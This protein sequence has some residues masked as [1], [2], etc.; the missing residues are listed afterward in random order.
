MPMHSNFSRWPR[1]A[2]IAGGVALAVIA[3]LATATLLLDDAFVR[4]FISKQ[5][6][7]RTGRTFEVRGPFAIDWSLRPQIV[8]EDLVF[9]NAK[10]GS[11]EEMARVKRATLRIDLAALLRGRVA[12]TELSLDAPDVLFERLAQSDTNP[13]GANWNFGDRPKQ[14]GGTAAGPEIRRLEI[15]NGVFY[16]RDASKK[17][18]LKIALASIPPTAGESP[19]A[20]ARLRIAG[21]GRFQG[22]AFKLDGVVDSLLALRTPD[23]PFRLNVRG[24]LGGT[25]AHID[26]SMIDPLNLGGMDIALDLRGPDIGKLHDLIKLPFPESPPYRLQGRLARTGSVWRF[27]D[28]HGRV[29]D[30]DIAGNF[31]IDVGGERSQMQIDVASRSLDFDDLAPLIGRAPKVGPGET[32]SREQKQEARREAAAPRVLPD[33]PFNLEKLRKADARFKFVAYKV[34]AGKAPLDSILAEG[35]LTN[36]RL[37][38]RKLDLGLAGGKV[39]GVVTLDAA[40][41]PIATD[42]DITLVRLDLA[43][44]VPQFGGLVKQGAGRFGGRAK[45]STRGNSIAAMAAGMN[46]EVGMAIGGGEISKLLTE[47]AGLEIGKALVTWARGDDNVKIRCGVGD[48][49]VDNGTMHVNTLVFDTENTKI[50]GHGSVNLAREALDLTLDAEPKSKSILT[51]TSPLELTGTLKNPGVGLKGKKLAGRALGAAALGAAAPP[52]AL[53]ALIGQGEGKDAD[54]G[55]LLA[56]VSRKT[57][58]AAGK[59]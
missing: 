32:A 25:Q 31:A 48:F 36:G 7:E 41:S 3:L 40:R 34:R 42:M 19:R 12:L 27:S 51:A 9:G 47:A 30:S 55:A 35:D 39:D 28:F 16:Y 24:T 50:V 49:R 59:R 46:G 44:L 13:S 37:H 1:G 23:D 21:D 22:G 6:A 18:D 8:A 2:K 45:F 4:S 52:A 29:G 57:Q 26:G 17:T 14:D 56:S 20:V 5:V 54:C 38:F 10:G 43:R 15:R 33:K 53:L 58:G 11:R